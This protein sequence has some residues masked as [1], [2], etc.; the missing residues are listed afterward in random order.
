MKYLITFFASLALAHGAFAADS[1]KEES[2][3]DSANA[4]AKATAATKDDNKKVQPKADKPKVKPI[5]KD[6]KPVDDK[7][8]TDSAKK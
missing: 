7:K 2:K 3:K 6:G 1:K 4:T 8:S 5:G